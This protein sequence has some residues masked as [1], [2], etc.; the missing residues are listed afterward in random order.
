MPEQAARFTHFKQRGGVFSRCWFIDW[1]ISVT[2]LNSPWNNPRWRAALEAHLPPSS[3]IVPKSLT[4]KQYQ[5]SKETFHALFCSVFCIM[6]E[7]L[8]KNGIAAFF[9][10]F[11][12]STSQAVSMFYWQQGKRPPHSRSILVSRAI[13][14]S[15]CTDS[16]IICIHDMFY[17]E[18]PSNSMFQLFSIHNPYFKVY[19]AD[20]SFVGEAVKYL[21]VTELREE[22]LFSQNRNVSSLYD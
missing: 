18:D 12:Y 1:A 4:H 14:F 16:I 13:T 6:Q 8:A 20:P 5:A 19:R 15:L 2:G 21:T 11:V 22:M 9:V 3:P 10:A 17:S 7:E